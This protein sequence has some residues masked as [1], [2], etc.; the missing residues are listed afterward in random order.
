MVGQVARSGRCPHR[1]DL[2]A[3]GRRVVINAVCDRFSLAL[4]IRYRLAPVWT[5]R[6]MLG[7]NEC[8]QRYPVGRAHAQ[9][10]SRARMVAKL[11]S[12]R[13]VQTLRQMLQ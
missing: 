3:D 8:G 6:R 12:C 1:D 9:L 11:R 13:H 2:F 4:M 10:L 5:Q 7:T